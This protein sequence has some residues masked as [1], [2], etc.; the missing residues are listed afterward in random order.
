MVRKKGN[1]CGIDSTTRTSALAQ[2]LGWFLVPKRW[3]S[4]MAAQVHSCSQVASTGDPSPKAGVP[5]GAATRVGET[6][7][8]GVRFTFGVL[9]RDQDLPSSFVHLSLMQDHLSTCHWL[10]ATL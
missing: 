5:Y 1:A 2:G 8:V 10:P 7:Q 9:P 6:D 3:A 4:Q